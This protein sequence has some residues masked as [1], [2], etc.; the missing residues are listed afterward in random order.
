MV[1]CALISTEASIQL[2]LL[3]VFNVT[4]LVYYLCFTPSKFKTTNYLNS[5]IHLSMIAYEIVL[6]MYNISDKSA[7]YQNTISIGLFIVVGLTV[8]AVLVWMIY[9]LVVFV[10]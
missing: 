1:V 3:M 9:R 7:T 2:I 4:A 8:F 10:R 5:F 6:F